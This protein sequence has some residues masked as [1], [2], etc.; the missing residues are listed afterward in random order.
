MN[1]THECCPCTCTW[2]LRSSVSGSVT[3]QRVWCS[4][5]HVEY[6]LNHVKCSLDRVE[7]PLNHVESSLS[8]VGSSQVLVCFFRPCPVL[9]RAPT[10]WLCLMPTLQS[11]RAERSVIS[12][13]VEP[14]ISTI[15]VV[16][17]WACCP[18]FS[19]AEQTNL[20]NNLPSF[21]DPLHY[22]AGSK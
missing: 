9:I 6:S 12:S 2:M 21:W 19:K 3:P 22:F 20:W 15:S 13:Q 8:H 1:V 7:C 4:L 16:N 11:G 17:T 5:N 14:D 10:R 18:F